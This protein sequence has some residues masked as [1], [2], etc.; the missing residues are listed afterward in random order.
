MNNKIASSIIDTPN[1]VKNAIKTAKS[2]GY[3]QYVRIEKDGSEAYGRLYSGINPY[4]IFSDTIIMRGVVKVEYL[5]GIPYARFY[6]AFT[7]PTKVKETLV[8]AGLDETQVSSFIGM[9]VKQIR[10]YIKHYVSLDKDLVLP[11]LNFFGTHPTHEKI[12]NVSFN[13]DMKTNKLELQYLETP[14]DARLHV[15]SIPFEYAFY[16]RLEVIRRVLT[17]RYRAIQMLKKS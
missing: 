7:E 10:N 9:P 5:N 13:V 12:Y 3:D 6:S 2:T 14:Q 11:S 1:I 16:A 15:M 4:M 8:S 17:K